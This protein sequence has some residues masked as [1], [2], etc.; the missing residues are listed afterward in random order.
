MKYL[1]VVI[2]TIGYLAVL[3]LIAGQVLSIMAS[4]NT[5]E[6]VG[7]TGLILAIGMFFAIKWQRSKKKVS[8]SELSEWK[9]D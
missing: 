2:Y 6:I 3:I 9:K 8:T 7:R 4:S 1:K 5:M